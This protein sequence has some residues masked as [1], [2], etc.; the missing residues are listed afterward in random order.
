MARQQALWVVVLIA[1]LGLIAFQVG[2]REGS[3]DEEGRART[4]AVADTV[5]EAS[6]AHRYRTG[7]YLTVEPVAVD[8]QA[9]VAT[10]DLRWGTAWRD[11]ETWEAAWIVLKGR[12]QADGVVVPLPVRA[13]PR[14]V[15]GSGD[16]HAEPAFEVPADRAGAFVYR[17]TSGAGAVAWRVEVPWEPG[18]SVD[19][20]YALGVEMVRVPTG[21]FLLG[22]ARSLS[23]RRVET[24]VGSGTAPINALFRVDPNGEDL[25]GGPYAV[26]SEAAIPIGTDAGD[27]YYID[28]TIPGVDTYS[29]DRE[30]PLPAAYPKGHEGFYMMKYEL[31]E[32]HYVQ[33]LNLLTPAQAR[34]RKDLSLRESGRPPRAYRHTIT[35]EGGRYQTPRPHRAASFLSWEDA[36]AWADWFGL[37]PMTELEFEKG[38]RGPEPVAFREFVWGVSEIDEPD[39]LRLSGRILDPGGAPAM[40]EDGDEYVDGNAH[41]AMLHYDD[42][43]D[44][45]QPDGIHYDPG[46]YA[47]RVFE[48]GDGSR[49]PLR[50]GIHGVA[51]AGDRIRSGATYYGAMDLGGNLREQVV[52]VGHPQGRAF[53]GTHGDGRL[54]EAGEAT[55]VD[56]SAAAETHYFA[57][58]GGSWRNAANH[59]RTAD[60]FFALRTGGRVRT[61]T[62]GFRGVR[63]APQQDP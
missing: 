28:A 37:R 36:M 47:C 11:A 19:S 57:F 58:R 54:T 21:P 62:L 48:G 55:N 5:S 24:S 63:T 7:A 60:R 14:S 52:T 39:H 31:T 10:L 40:A 15:A 6:R 50:V 16:A 33:F 25:F 17:A 22:T 1:A 51:G 34:Q 27:L 9:H 4:P 2:P 49:G 41:V 32:G 29:G 35:Q 3:G 23:A 26:T 53:R 44:V 61:S 12:R 8:T 43:A 18:S 45:C 56:W 30:G 42:A 38:A 20:I 59:A 13:S 46:Y